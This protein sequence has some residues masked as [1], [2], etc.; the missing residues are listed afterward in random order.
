MKKVVFRN[1]TKFT[2][3]HL[4][5]SLFFNKVAG[6][7]NRC[8]PVNFVRSPTISFYSTLLDD[9]FY[10]NIR[11]IQNISKLVSAILYQIFIF[12]SNDRPSKT[13]KYVFLF[14]LKSSFRFQDTQIFVTFSLPFHTLQIQ[15]GK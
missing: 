13:M 4:C 5:Q 2:G 1:F 15:K 6:L 10:V 12:S 14:H 8:F 9:Y 3:K 11:Q 7:R